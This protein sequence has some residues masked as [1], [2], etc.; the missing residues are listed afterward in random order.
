MLQRV[1][2]KKTLILGA[3]PNPARYS[4]R[5]TEML[6]DYKHE[7]I[8]LGFRKGKIG[9]EDILLDQIEYENVD[10]ITVYMNA[11]RQQALHNYI[12]SLKPRR[13]IFNP[14][15]ENPILEGLAHSKGIETLN[16]CTLVMLT[17]GNY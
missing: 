13:I 14:G 17:I 5:A 1:S 11:Q 10:T 4:Y 16:A 2:D 9:D 12:L 8:P 7:V 3:S 6:K 15:A